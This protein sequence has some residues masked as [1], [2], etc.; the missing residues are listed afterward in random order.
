MFSSGK[1]GS[2]YAGATPKSLWRKAVALVALVLGV[3]PIAR[4]DRVGEMT[5]GSPIWEA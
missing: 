1:T 3:T 4:T 2:D 5:L